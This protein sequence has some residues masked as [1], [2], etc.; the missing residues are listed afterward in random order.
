MRAARRHRALA[1][2]TGA[3]TATTVISGAYVAGNDA[4]RAYNTWPKMG[5]EWIP[6]GMWT[7]SPAWRNLAENTATVQVRCDAMR[8]D[9]MRCD[10]AICVIIC[11]L[12]LQ[13]P[14]SPRQF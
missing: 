1:I 14:P 6:E 2:G 8:C 12:S 7:L 4:G 13:N 5:D 3:L 10:D 9:A 11:V